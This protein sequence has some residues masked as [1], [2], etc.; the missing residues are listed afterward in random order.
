MLPN[1]QEAMGGS[2]GQRG[3]L[4]G[5]A[6]GCYIRIDEIRRL[7]VGAEQAAWAWFDPKV[8]FLLWNTEATFM[9]QLMVKRLPVYAN[10]LY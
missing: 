2:L 6:W 8:C 4:R 5:A 3:L 7:S 9:Q 1:M 10:F